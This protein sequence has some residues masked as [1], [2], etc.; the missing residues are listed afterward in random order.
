MDTDNR[1]IFHDRII[2]TG[3]GESK[4]A[5][6]FNKGFFF[7]LRG[8]FWNYNAKSVSIPYMPLKEYD[9]IYAVELERFLDNNPYGYA[10]QMRVRKD[11]TL[12][13]LEYTEYDLLFKNDFEICLL[14]C[15]ILSVC[16]CAELM[17]RIHKRVINQFLKEKE[18]AEYNDYFKDD[19][20]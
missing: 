2:K 10:K 8:T 14:Q 5:V 9:G 11:L 1:L 16:H 18:A 6:R 20:L 4:F 15:N 7:P 12:I 17:M 19:R 3:K 13:L